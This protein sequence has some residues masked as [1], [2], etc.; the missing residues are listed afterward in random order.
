MWQE[1][2]VEEGVEKQDTHSSLHYSTF[3]F[4]G[5]VSFVLPQTRMAVKPGGGT[6]SL[7]SAMFTHKGE[8]GPLVLNVADSI[9]DITAASSLPLS[10]HRIPRR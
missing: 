8:R 1:N 10:P 6:Y 4:V 2:R 3:T 7:Y 9:P 5:F